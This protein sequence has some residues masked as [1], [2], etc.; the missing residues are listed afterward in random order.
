M[1]WREH[2]PGDKHEQ[3]N[4]GVAAI[5]VIFG[6][7]IL[8]GLGMAFMFN[9]GAK[10]AKPAQLPQ[11]NTGIV[12]LYTKDLNVVTWKTSRLV[13]VNGTGSLYFTDLSTGKTFN[14]LPADGFLISTN[15]Q[16]CPNL[17]GDVSP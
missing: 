6:V 17:K 4:K 5:V 13:G 10:S 12:C 8:F 3:E 11:D 15:A 7:V 9:K 1:S 14:I 16:E 2:Q